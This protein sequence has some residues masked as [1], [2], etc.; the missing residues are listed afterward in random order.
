[1]ER[2]IGTIKRLTDKGYGFIYTPTI[3]RD[4]FFH[5]RNLPRGTSIDSIKEGDEVEFDLHETDKGY[6]AINIILLN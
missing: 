5:A 1:M 4:I 2:L 6:N 3:T